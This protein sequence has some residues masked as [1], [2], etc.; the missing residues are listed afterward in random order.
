MTR[1]FVAICLDESTRATVAAEI[2][3]LRPLGR[4]V[5][6]VP[7]ENLHLTLKFLGGQS[8]E[9]LAEVVQ[10]LEQAG[11]GQAPFAIRL[12]G[13]GAFPGM[14]HPRILWI[15]VAEGVPAM[16]ALQSAVESELGRRGFAPEDRA[17]HAHL[18]IGRVFDPRRWRRDASPALRE[19]IAHAATRDFG[20]LEVARV[21]LMRSDLGRAGARYSELRSVGLAAE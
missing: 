19:S 12:H 15:G 8:D 16:R 14:E 13:L 11:S 17:W 10:A 7:P 9:R 20:T 3:R 4:A 6:W 2:E 21:V 5:A 1:A 18:T